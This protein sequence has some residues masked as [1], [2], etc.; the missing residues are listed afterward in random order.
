VFAWTQTRYIV[1]GWYGIG[2]ALHAVIEA[3]GKNLKRL[4]ARYADWLFFQAVVNNAQ[5]EMARARLDI[6]RTYATHLDPEG[7]DP[8]HDR[9]ADDFAWARDAILQI[10]GQ[11]HL[12]DNAPVIQKSISLRN[13]YTDVLNLL[14]IEL[15]QRRRGNAEGDPEALGQALFLSV[16]GIAAAMQSTG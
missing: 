15:L 3:D 11:D 10:T 7:P 16:N 6:A 14:Q 1:P 9:I 4:Q 8:L 13:P 5:R 2:Q 12:L